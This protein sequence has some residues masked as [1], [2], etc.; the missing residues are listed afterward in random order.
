MMKKFQRMSTFLVGFI[1]CLTGVWSFFYQDIL[2]RFPSE[3]REW[4]VIHGITGQILFIIFGMSLNGHALHYLK[5]GK[6]MKWGLIFFVALL[7]NFV[8]IF[9]LYYGNLEAREI[10]HV[11]H[12][13]MGFLIFFSF[14]CHLHFGKIYRSMKKPKYNH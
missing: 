13:L 11:L 10:M 3:Y 12:V 2:E 8:T 5:D 9:F 14:L 7:L 4:I 6:K 1:C